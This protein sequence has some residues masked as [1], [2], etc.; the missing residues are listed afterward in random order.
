MTKHDDIPTAD[1]AQIEQL[2]ERL[3]Q[4]DLE[5]HETQLLERVLRTFLSLVSL[6]QQKNASIKNLK[7]MIFGPK[8]EKPVKPVPIR[9]AAVSSIIYQKAKELLSSGAIGQLNLVDSSLWRR[10]AQSAWQY[11]IP[12]DASPQ[13]G[14]RGPIASSAATA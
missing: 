5:P 9:R 12:P 3:K 14:A 11:S 6:L 1:P 13:T 4:T 8:T 7:Q 2:I 10:G